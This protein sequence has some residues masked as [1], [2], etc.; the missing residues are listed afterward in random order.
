M[1]TTAL[2]SALKETPKAGDGYDPNHPARATDVR[3]V[4]AEAGVVTGTRRKIAVAGFASSSREQIP[5]NDPEWEV[6]GLN[7]LYRH[8]PRADR[9]FDIHWNW[10]KEVV[11]GTDYRGWLRDCGIPVYMMERQP[12]LPTSVRFPLE[13]LNER[14]TDYYTSTIA[15]M[16]ALAT[17]EIETRVVAQLV[18]EAP[19]YLPNPVGLLARR[20]ELFASYTIGIYGVDLVVGEEYDWQKAC[21]EFWI[22][23]A[24]MGLGITIKIPSQSAL[25]KQLYRYGYQSEPDGLVRLSEITKHRENLLRERESLMRELYLRDGALQADE[26]WS[27]LLTLRARGAEVKI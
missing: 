11:P 8:I 9:W 18:E 17:E 24:A 1:T 10:D 14:F 25:C 21:A 6:W 27:Q 22:G 26:Y 20:E 5:V 7:Q 16:V 4:D 15:F 13:R 12:D 23:A 19:L 3:I 2:N